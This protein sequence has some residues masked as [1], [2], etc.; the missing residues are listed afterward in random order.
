MS[1]CGS[2][3]KD[4]DTSPRLARF[5]AM[6]L[7]LFLAASL[8][9]SSIQTNPTS[10]APLGGLPIQTN[11]ASAPVIEPTPAAALGL[12]EKD[13]VLMGWALKRHDLDKDAVLEAPEA[14]GAAEEFRE[15]ADGDGDGR[16]SRLEY[17]QAREFIV[18]RY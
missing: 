12:F 3:G 8:V 9:G 1:L 18:A 2:A 6:S 13:W 16:V 7:M 4:V 11:R 17:R 14:A 5:A 15:I 10:A